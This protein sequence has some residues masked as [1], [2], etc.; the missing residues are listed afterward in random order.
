MVE[1]C[2]SERIGKVYTLDPPQIL[3]VFSKSSSSN[4]WPM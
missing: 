1:V 2:V 3:A 4:S